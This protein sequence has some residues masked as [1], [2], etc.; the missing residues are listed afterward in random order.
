MLYRPYYL[1]TLGSSNTNY[2][3]IS[4]NVEIFTPPKKKKN[5]KKFFLKENIEFWKNIEF[6][7]KLKIL[8][9]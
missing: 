1:L 3:I 9:N 7:W 4:R 6:F 2:I 5:Q 8:I